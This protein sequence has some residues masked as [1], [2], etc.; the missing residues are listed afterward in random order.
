[1]CPG[2]GCALPRKRGDFGKVLEGDDLTWGWGEG[3]C[4]PRL[5]R[6]K[7]PEPHKQGTTSHSEV[8]MY[9]HLVTI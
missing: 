9:C 6:G 3:G 8:V 2:S 7:P 4:C 1:M 5:Y